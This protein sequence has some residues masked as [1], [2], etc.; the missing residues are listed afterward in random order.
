[1]SEINS[2]NQLSVCQKYYSEGMVGSPEINRHLTTLPTIDCQDSR[3][4]IPFGIYNAPLNRLGL[5]AT[6]LVYDDDS[7]IQLYLLETVDDTGNRIALANSIGYSPKKE[8]AY[9]GFLIDVDHAN[10]I[11]SVK[12]VIGRDVVKL[13]AHESYSLDLHLKSSVIQATTN[14]KTFWLDLGHND[15]NELIVID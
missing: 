14:H 6:K 1:M 10:R 13:L 5:L 3:H 8:R 7:A 9:T 12:G 2:L 11:D 15:T 4:T